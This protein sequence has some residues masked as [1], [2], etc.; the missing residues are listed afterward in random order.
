ML[1]LCLFALVGFAIEVQGGMSPEASKLLG[2]ADFFI[3]CFFLLDFF[4][5]LARADN[6]LRYFYTW[7]WLDL[8]SSIPAI[9]PLRIG[10]AARVVRIIKILRGVRSVRLIVQSISEQRKQSVAFAAILT[11]ILTV[12]LASIGILHF[13]QVP[14]GNIRTAGDALWWAIETITTVGYGDLYPVT[15]GGRILG[16]LLMILGVGLFGVITGLVA[17]WFIG[18]EQDQPEDR[19][20]TVCPNCSIS[21]EV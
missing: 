15:G 20:I 16:S 8:I 18:T 21:V 17:S 5:N 14:T 13:E 4:L 11:T 6:R 3:C 9:G 12:A 10:R 2:Y 7:G 19:N 1:I